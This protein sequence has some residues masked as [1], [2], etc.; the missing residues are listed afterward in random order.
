VATALALTGFLMP[1][2]IPWPL[3]LLV[4]V[5]AFGFMQV[6]EAFKMNPKRE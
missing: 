3:A 2:A 6:E 4:W 5:W 1:A